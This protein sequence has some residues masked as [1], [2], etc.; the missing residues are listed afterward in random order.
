MHPQFSDSWKWP[1]FFDAYIDW[2]RYGD[3]SEA[4]CILFRITRRVRNTLG[5]APMTL[6]Q[7]D[8]QIMLCEAWHEIKHEGCVQERFDG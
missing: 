7:A 5:H 6:A 8:V 1:Q 2:R 3:A 4:E